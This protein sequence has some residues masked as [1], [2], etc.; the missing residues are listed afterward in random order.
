MYLII[1][2]DSCTGHSDYMLKFHVSMVLCY[3]VSAYQLYV[4]FY[5]IA[6]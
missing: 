3:V 6:M 4:G 5:K 2:P 1:K